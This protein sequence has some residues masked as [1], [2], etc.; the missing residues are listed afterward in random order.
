MSLAEISTPKR[1]EVK[2]ARRQLDRMMDDDEPQQTPPLNQAGLNQALFQDV[3]SHLS[4]NGG[5]ETSDTQ[6]LGVSFAGS[7]TGE[8]E[9]G[10][11]AS[12]IVER[13]DQLAKN[14]QNGFGQVAKSI[15][16]LKTICDTQR[17][18]LK[19]N[20]IAWLDTV[21]AKV[22]NNT[23]RMNAMETNQVDI[24]V[25]II[26]HHKEKERLATTIFIAGAESQEKALQV[27]KTITDSEDV[28]KNPEVEIRHVTKNDPRKRNNQRP[29]PIKMD[30][31]E[32]GDDDTQTREEDSTK[33][34]EEKDGKN[35]LYVGT[36]VKLTKTLFEAALKG[37][38]KLRK[39]PDTD[40][41]FVNKAKTGLERRV[42]SQK[43]NEIA[44]L[45][46]TQI[47][48]KVTF[49]GKQVDLT[50]GKFYVAEDMRVRFKP[51]KQ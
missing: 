16:D 1:N 8:P 32:K 13:I 18:E 4:R 33:N 44:K 28:H 46:A 5:D 21:G 19:N 12:A 51:N 2:N 9:Q 20:I 10:A 34:K 47:N 3:S 49:Q 24:N 41:V 37:K 6:S 38:S 27:L 17:D 36:Q 39:N 7:Q 29:A 22:E 40:Y 35:E 42:R 26:N 43:M 15:E 48:D 31:Y 11:I 14:T 23:K 45:K 25:A 30:E 50:K